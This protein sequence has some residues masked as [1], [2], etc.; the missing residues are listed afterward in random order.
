MGRRRN[1]LGSQGLE[2]MKIN[3]A[4]TRMTS[5]NYYEVVRDYFTIVRQSVVGRLI[6]RGLSVDR[7]L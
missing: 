3:V 5:T 1:I 2:V 6:T 4:F 7:H